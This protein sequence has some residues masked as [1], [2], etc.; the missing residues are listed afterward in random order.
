MQMHA[1]WEINNR[2][3]RQA[4]LQGYDLTGITETWWDGSYDWSVGMEESR[5]FK[6]DSQGR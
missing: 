4:H 1:V 5:L 6:K 3:W 2:T